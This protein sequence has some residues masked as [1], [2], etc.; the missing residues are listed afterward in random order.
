MKQIDETKLATLTAGL[1]TNV[2]ALIVKFTADATTL[3]SDLPVVVTPPPVIVTPPPVNTGTGTNVGTG[4]G[5]LVIDGAKTAYKSPIAIKPGNYSSITIQSLSNVDVIGTGVIIN[6]ASLTL[7]ALNTSKISGITVQNVKG[8]YMTVNSRLA[9]VTI[10]TFTAINCT[11]QFRV[12]YKVNWD[13]TDNTVQLLNL[14]FTKCTFNNVGT[15]YLDGSVWSGPIVNMVKNLE[16]ANCAWLN[17]DAGNMIDS[18]AVDGFKIHDNTFTNINVNNRNVDTRLVMMVGHGDAYNNTFTET[19]GHSIAINPLSFSKS[20]RSKFSF[21]KNV[22]NHTYKYSQYEVQ[23]FA[24]QLTSQTQ[25]CDG[26]I[27]SSVAKDINTDHYDFNGAVVDNY[28]GSN[29]AIKDACIL[30]L[31]NCTLQNAYQKTAPPISFWNGPAPASSSGNVY[32]A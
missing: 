7:A 29:P 22:T 4:N 30:S 3:L 28:V 32:I 16:V 12:N 21:Y 24:E 8:D 20:V 17:S 2:D 19:C 5:S 13:G 23:Q 18:R 27:D 10:D 6:G 14:T 25:A 26:S 11:G 1:K 15:L 9:N 31:T